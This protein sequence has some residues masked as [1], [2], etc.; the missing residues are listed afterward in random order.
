MSGDLPKLPIHSSNTHPVAAMSR[1]GEL[2][3]G[4]EDGLILF[5]VSGDGGGWWCQDFGCGWSESYAAMQHQWFLG[6]KHE[7]RI[8]WTRAESCGG[9]D[10]TLEATVAHWITRKSENTPHN[11][12]LVH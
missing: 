4:A 11:E 9:L 5:V 1:A 3:P 7:G 12:R 2:Q 10:V 8:S 6:V